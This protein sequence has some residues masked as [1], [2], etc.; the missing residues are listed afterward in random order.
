[1]NL[2]KKLSEKFKLLSDFLVSNR[3][4]LNDDKTHLMV[5]TTS[6][7]RR[8][9]ICDL[10]VTITTPTKTVTATPVERL[11]GGWIDQDLKWAEHILH[12]KESLVRGLTT[13]VSALKM[14]CKAAPL[15]VRKIIVDGI[16]TSKLSYLI[17]L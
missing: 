15:K 2:S 6:Q 14:V 9:N 16:F 7:K 1:M 11:L 4:K 12:N 8:R 5:L 10:Q 13:R 3:L 17:S